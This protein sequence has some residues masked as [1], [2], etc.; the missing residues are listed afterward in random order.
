MQTQPDKIVNLPQD[1]IPIDKGGAD[2]ALKVITKD[3]DAIKSDQAVKTKDIKIIFDDT[4]KR[5]EDWKK[6]P[7]KEKQEEARIALGEKIAW[8]FSVSV[9]IF[10]VTGCGIAAFSD[11]TH[12]K[13]FISVVQ[14]IGALLTWAVGFVMG[15]YFTNK[16]SR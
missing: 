14:T 1:N 16:D 3:Y 10:V 15:H 8:T 4:R 11:E 6:K 7:I 13:N 12:I 9:M 5:S 2:S